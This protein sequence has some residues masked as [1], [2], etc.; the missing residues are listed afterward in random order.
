VNHASSSPV[1]TEAKRYLRHHAVLESA[2]GQAHTYLNQIW[3]QLNRVITRELG[4]ELRHDNWIEIIPFEEDQIVGLRW[5]SQ[6]LQGGVILEVADVRRWTQVSGDHIVYTVS[7]Q[8][9]QTRAMLA[10]R[11]SDMQIDQAFQQMNCPISLLKYG[12]ESSRVISIAS[13]LR[14]TD[15]RQEAQMV[16]EGIVSLWEIIEGE[17]QSNH[18]SALNS[19]HEPDYEKTPRYASAAP[20][21][22]APSERT[23]PTK[24]QPE[25]TMRSIPRATASSRPIPAPFPPTLAP[26]A[27]PAVDDR[28]VYDTNSNDTQ[29][30]VD[31][32]MAMDEVEQAFAGMTKE[33][34]IQAIQ[35]QV[36]QRPGRLIRGG[37]RKAAPVLSEPP[38]FIPRSLGTGEGE[39]VSQTNRRSDADQEGRV[40]NPDQTVESVDLADVITNPSPVPSVSTPQVNPALEQALL[41]KKGIEQP[42]YIMKLDVEDDEVHHSSVIIKAPA[43]QEESDGF[44]LSVND[45]TPLEGEGQI[46]SEGLSTIEAKELDV[47][48]LKGILERLGMPAWRVN[49]YDEGRGQI[50][51]LNNGAHIDY[52]PAGDVILGGENQDETRARLSQMGIIL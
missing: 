18:E 3:L 5:R 9:K 33:E 7:S 50:L 24:P 49:S 40:L 37:E 11:C 16:I 4:G 27:A 1:D 44:D 2:R 41:S 46:G 22:S 47:R 39:I 8:N 42:S 26:V 43:E 15:P 38:R 10:E 19:T 25:Q 12:A 48:S 14:F 32:Q 45:G 36:R 6:S 20:P 30:L 35:A 28:E 23:T 52:N 21:I 34:M 51:W 31:D 13:P 29:E 17:T